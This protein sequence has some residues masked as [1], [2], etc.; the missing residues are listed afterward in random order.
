MDQK[1][2]A[3]RLIEIWDVINFL[4]DECHDYEYIP[5]LRE[6]MDKLY[7]KLSPENQKKFIDWLIKGLEKKAGV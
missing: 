2:I 7:L 5:A 6:V 3:K 1:E 4:C